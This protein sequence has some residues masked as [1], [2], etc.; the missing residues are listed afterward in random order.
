MA[1]KPQN[2]P[3]QGIRILDLTRL[4]PGPLGTMML[5]DMGADV[6]KI[7]DINA[8]DY[9]RYYPPY[10]ESESAG[11][12]AVNRS[13]RS[14]ALNLKT[15]K[16]AGI[17]LSLIKTAD[18]VIEQFRPGVLAELGIGYKDA[19]LAKPDIIYVSITGY[20]QDGPYANDAGHDINFMGY[21]GI[22]AA[23]GACGT[24]PVIPG[25]QLGDVAGGAYM[26]VI[27]CLSALWA[28]EK[29]GKGQQV[30]V[31]MLDGVLPLMTLQMAHYQATRISFAPGEP[32][33]SGGLA[34]YGV[35]S[36]ADGKHIALGILETKFWKIFCEMTG[37]PEW[38][39]KHLVMGEEAESL[40]REIA[41]LFRTKTRDEWMI[42]AKT[43]DVCLT[44]VLD[45]SEIEKDPQIKARRMIH[46]QAH[47]VSGKIKGIGV[48][49]KFSETPAEPAWP[50]PA[51]GQDSKSILEE[52]GCRPEEIEA[53]R[54]EGIALI[55]D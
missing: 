29:T 31:S 14:L 11:F 15:K 10:I 19:C 13:K 37:H 23:T 52:I 40:R 46:E 26:S 8:P 42:A 44:P 3:L 2:G 22:L 43:L 6:I 32:P 41:D 18:I 36:C 30:D 51:L 1:R 12:I 49:L 17:F 39:E 34:C 50:S 55:P 24:G 35:Y 7:E 45:I 48:P 16:G 20:G 47:P 27:A 21:A 4:Y 25:P 54:Q 53:F 5:A 38:I 33:L 28:R 9:M